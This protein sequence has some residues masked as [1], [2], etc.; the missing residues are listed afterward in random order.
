MTKTVSEQIL[1]AAHLDHKVGLRLA[2]VTD[3]IAAE[4]KYHL[5]CLR[6]FTRSTTKTK[7]VAAD[8]NLAMVWLLK[9]LHYVAEKGQVVQLNDVWERYKKLAEDSSTTIPQSYYSRRTTFKEKLQSNLGDMFSF[10]QPLDR[11]PPERQTLMI[12]A[13]FQH[14]TILQLAAENQEDDETLTMPRYEPEEDI[15]LSLI[16]LALKVCSD[17]MATPGHKGLSVNEEEAAECVP[18]SL[19]MFLRLI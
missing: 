13:K 3:L 14:T 16:H 12:P 5:P 7:Q 6:A 9:E 10:F 4:A 19:Y 8:T 17:M 11:C 1:Q 15:F 18:D 2:G